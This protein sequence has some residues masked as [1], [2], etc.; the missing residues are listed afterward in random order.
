MTKR[1]HNWEQQPVPALFPRVYLEYAQAQGLEVAV[2]LTRAGLPD[3]LP[4]QPNPELSFLQLRDLV[5][6][7]IQALGDDSLGVDIGLRL[8]PTA[9]GNLGYALLCSETLEQAA[10]LLIRYWNL[11]GRAVN[12]SLSTEAP[13]CVL[14]L[15]H[16]FPLPAPLDHLS[17]ESTM[18][19]FHRGFQLLVAA[20]EE[21]MEIWFQRPPPAYADKIRALLGNVH[22]D[23]P[24]NQF[25][26]RTE[27]M[28]KR[29]P[30]HNPTGLQFAIQQ[31]QREE[32]L[33]NDSGYVLRE[34]VRQEMVYGPEGYA[35]LEDISQRL[36]MTAR[37]LRRKLEEE[38]THFKALLEEA[39]RRD[40][41]QLLDDRHLE[42][43]RVATLL[44]YQDPAN[45]TR[46]FRQWTGQTPSQ[47][48]NTRNSA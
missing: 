31:C 6:A 48:R 22:F 21:D 28:Q 37:T 43:Q 10:S 47:Y 4:Q 20:R 38:G 18:A 8:P 16:V 30:M 23:M 5:N 33:L 32:A 13:Q 19:S 24:A 15:N 11:L 44:G 3:T 35:T 7:I 2:V 41:I 26:F 17:Y 29:L 25:R 36:N 1:K 34:K 42:I 46:A 27:L 40:A 9:Y 12:V 39:K 45:F 14:D